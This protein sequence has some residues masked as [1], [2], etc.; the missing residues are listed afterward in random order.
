M[1]RQTATEPPQDWL[2]SGVR[3][4]LHRCCSI[5]WKVDL[6]VAVSGVERTEAEVPARAAH[7]EIGPYSREKRGSIDVIVA[8]A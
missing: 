7:E 3:A 8:A 5:C 6:V 1:G 4:W 2:G